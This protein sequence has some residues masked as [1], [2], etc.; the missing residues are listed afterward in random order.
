MIKIKKFVTDKL[1]ILS[2]KFIELTNFFKVSNINT[3]ASMCLMGLGQIMYGQI[4]KGILY[5]C[6]E[7]LFVI[8]F[9]LFGFSWLVGLFTLG[10]VEA[11]PW[12]G[13][14]GDNS[15]IF[16]LLGIFSVFIIVLFIS[17]YISNIKDANETNKNIIQGR[18]PSTFKEDL[19]DLLDKKFYKSVL[20]FPIIGTLIFSILPIVFMIL[21]A[22][23]NYGYP[24]LPPALVDWVGLE[25]FEKIFSI[26][27][28]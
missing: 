16:L 20:F 4:G 7:I 22:F 25:N 9:T 17:L 21:I 3:R 14:E 23:T 1:R 15:V 28:V 2:D 18:K 6:I 13:T 8:F 5:L 26:G 11:D 12:T 19:L 27:E 24:I 10:T